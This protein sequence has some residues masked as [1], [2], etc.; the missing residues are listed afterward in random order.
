MSYNN[1][2][3]LPDPKP[4]SGK[5]NQTTERLCV[6]AKSLADLLDVSVRQIHNMNGSG[7]LGP[8]AI[9]LSERCLRWDFGE[10]RT[11]WAASKA[12]GR[13]LSRREWLEQRAKEAS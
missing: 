1:T 6:S 7:A 11:W 10:V 2:V 13:P 3:T 12:A 8:I 5:H 4:V 9:Q